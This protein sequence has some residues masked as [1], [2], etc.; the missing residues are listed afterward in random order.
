MSIPAYPFGA[1]AFGVP[2]IASGFGIPITTG[3]YFY[4][5]S[6]IGAD[7]NPGTAVAPLATIKA[8]IN[9]CTANNYDCVV[10]MPKHAENIS[11]PSYIV[12]PAGT[13]LCGLGTGTLRPVLTWLTPT[14]TI[15][16]SAANCTFQNF[17][18]TAAVTETITLFSISAADC[19]INAV[20]YVEVA[21]VSVVS[22]ATSSSAANRLSI[23]NC[24]HTTTTVCTTTGAGWINIVGGDSIKIWDN[25][26]LANR[27]NSATGGIIVC[28]ST[29]TT[30]ISILRNTLGSQTSN[31]LTL[32]ISLLASSTGLVAYNNCSNLGKTSNVTGT[33]GIANCMATQNFATRTVTKS[34]LLDPVA[35]S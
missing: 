30:N 8:A 19:T 21:A 14:C 3:N 15:V 32:T 24:F 34:G 1:T 4:V 28:L 20:D 12:P 6:V 23:L 2:Q 18:C 27:A 33:V 35:D 11:T 10:M 13:I 25:I 29:I 5:S 26:I 31:A 17:V 22:F 9:K 16:V 7:T